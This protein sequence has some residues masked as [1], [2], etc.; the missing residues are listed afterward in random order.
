MIYFFESLNWIIYLSDKKKLTV[1]TNQNKSVLVLH[2]NC[3]Y[4]DFWSILWR[5][6]GEWGLGTRPYQ[7]VLCLTVPLMLVFAGLNDRKLQLVKYLIMSLVFL[8]FFYNFQ[9]FVVKCV[10]ANLKACQ[11][12]SLWIEIKNWY[13]QVEDFSSNWHVYLKISSMQK[14]IHYIYNPKEKVGILLTS[15]LTADSI[16]SIGDKLDLLPNYPAL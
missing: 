10:P 1:I 4:V 5:G 2:Y 14:Y 12:K 15:L 11:K 6:V 16:L 13:S 7:A 3:V 8:V 9:E